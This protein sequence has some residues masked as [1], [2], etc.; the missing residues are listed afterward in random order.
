M[1]FFDTYRLYIFGGMV[2]LLLGY[3]GYQ[4]VQIYF[5]DSKIEKQEET[6]EDLQWEV[7]DTKEEAEINASARVTKYMEKKYNEKITATLNSNNVVTGTNKL[8]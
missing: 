7:I 1:K 8:R 5:K 3:I 2:L 4:E 6:I